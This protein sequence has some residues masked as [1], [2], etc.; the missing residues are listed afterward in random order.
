MPLAEEAT[1]R[2]GTQAP[3]AALGRPP[4][5]SRYFRGDASRTTLD[6]ASPAVPGFLFVRGLVSG[7]GDV[8]D[9]R[10][11]EPGDVLGGGDE[12]GGEQ[13]LVP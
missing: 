1:G 12:P 8:V 2:T 3:L 10:G 13:R 5:S 4:P 7:L 9:D 6:A 11:K